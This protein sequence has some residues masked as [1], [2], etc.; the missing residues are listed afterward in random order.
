MNTNGTDWNRHGAVGAT[1][2]ENWVEERAVGDKVIEER[3]VRR[4]SRSGHV[5]VLVHDTGTPFKDEAPHATVSR[6]AYTYDTARKKPGLGK[7][8]QLVE[9]ELLGRA[10]EDVKF[11]V[12][13]P[14]QEEWVSLT[15]KDYNKTFTPSLDIDHPE[16]QYDADLAA[17]YKLPITYWSS[18]YERGEI[19]ASTPLDRH[20][21]AVDRTR[22]REDYPDARSGSLGHRP[23]KFGRHTDF[24][25]PIEDYV[26]APVKDL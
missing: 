20:Q 19:I 2:L 24:S 15:H 18:E 10:I 8:R 13:Q 22:T 25:T 12:S 3:D 6:L 4:L 1:L 17:K 9:A 21:K 16:R 11:R 26:K 5:G 23:V 7:R 14:T